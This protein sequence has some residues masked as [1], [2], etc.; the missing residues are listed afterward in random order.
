MQ[1]YPE[2]RCAGA[3]PRVLLWWDWSRG[4][5]TAPPVLDNTRT[6]EGDE[7]APCVSL[8]AH[9]FAYCV[10]RKA[11]ESIFSAVLQNKRNRLCETPEG[12]FLCFPLSVCAR[13][14]RAVRNKPPVVFFDDRSELV[15]HF[16][17]RQRRIHEVLWLLVTEAYDILL[18]HTALSVVGQ[19][20]YVVGSLWISHP[21]WGKSPT[22][23]RRAS[24]IDPRECE[25][26][27]PLSNSL[28]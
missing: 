25:R 20:D 23:G 14:L 18:H 24:L 4:N 13:Y 22:A 15:F 7:A 1:A 12:F 16:T 11:S 3:Q 21:Q 17:P 28:R 5:G 2:S 9:R 26:G 8:N 10:G 27:A 6:C 19:Y